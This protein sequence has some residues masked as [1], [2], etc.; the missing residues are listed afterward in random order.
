M[1]IIFAFNIKL[2]VLHISDML[3]DTVMLQLQLYYTPQLE[4]CGIIDL[5]QWMTDP[6]IIRFGI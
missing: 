5:A 4:Y 1:Q 3:L 2:N 6:L